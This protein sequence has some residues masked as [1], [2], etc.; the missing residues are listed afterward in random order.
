METRGDGGL[1]TYQVTLNFRVQKSHLEPL[2]I[3]QRTLEIFAFR[4]V[5]RPIVK[6]TVEIGGGRT[7]QV[8]KEKAANKR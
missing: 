5:V 3:V 6:M 7:S 2:L 8:I 1:K 4:R